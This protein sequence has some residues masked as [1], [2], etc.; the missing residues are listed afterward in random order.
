MIRRPPRSTLF[1]YTTLFRSIR[2]AIDALTRL[3]GEVAREVFT[4]DQEVY[5]LQLQ[6][7]HTCVD[8]I[9]LHA[10]V[11]LDVRTITASL[12]ITNN[13]DRIDR[14]TEDLGALTL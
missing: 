13:L 1:P 10:P 3:D 5:G 7:E 6:I 11:A 14:Y 4:I 12:K 8:L 2:K 9:A